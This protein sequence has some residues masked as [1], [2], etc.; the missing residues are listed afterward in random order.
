MAAVFGIGK[1]V[2]ETVNFFHSLFDDSSS[3]AAT[4]GT[5]ANDI[6]NIADIDNY[7]HCIPE[8]YW[9]SLLYEGSLERAWLTW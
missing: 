8:E 3:A 4:Y 7:V 5:D 2:T 9:H 1:A 6:A